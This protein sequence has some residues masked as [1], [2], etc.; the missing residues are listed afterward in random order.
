LRYLN[1]FKA[2][3]NQTHIYAA[4]FYRR[5]T[6]FEKA[7]SPMIQAYLCPNKIFLRKAFPPVKIQSNLLEKCCSRF[8]QKMQSGYPE[9]AIFS[10]HPFIT[11]S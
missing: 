4:A 11:S 10:N 3:T 8:I 6:E 7:E 2:R 9:I 5:E 1:F